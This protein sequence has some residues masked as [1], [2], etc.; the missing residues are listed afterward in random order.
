MKRYS[1][2]AMSRDEVNLLLYFESRLVDHFGMVNPFQI[3]GDDLTVAHRWKDEGL[4]TCSCA[5]IPP[6]PSMH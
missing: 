5:A 3:N 4:V 1:L 6:H 2:N